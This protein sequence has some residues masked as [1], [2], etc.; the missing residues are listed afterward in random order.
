MKLWHQT[1]IRFVL[2]FEMLAHRLHTSKLKHLLYHFSTFVNFNF[3]LFYRIGNKSLHCD[4]Y[5]WWSTKSIS[6]IDR[7]KREYLMKDNTCIKRQFIVGFNVSMLK[8]SYFTDNLSIFYSIKLIEC[9]TYMTAQR[10][11]HAIK[12]KVQ[13]ECGEVW[14]WNDERLCSV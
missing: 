14:S 12:Y 1:C 6:T 9:R 10:P 2:S 4:N 5:N 3:N 8:Y 7:P 13:C 11:K